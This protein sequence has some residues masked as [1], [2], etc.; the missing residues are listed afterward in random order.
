VRVANFPV[1]FF[2]CHSLDR[3]LRVHTRSVAQALPCVDEDFDNNCSRA[4]LQTMLE[5]ETMKATKTEIQL[6]VS[7]LVQ[8]RLE[9]ARFWDVRQYVTEKERQPGSIR[10]RGENAKALSDATLW[11]YIR[12]ADELIEE[13]TR[14]SRKKRIRLH[15]AKRQN[16]FAKAI[17]Q[18]DVRTALAA[19]DSE[20]KLLGLFP[21]NGVGVGIL[22]VA[23]AS[24]AA[25]N[26][27]SPKNVKDILAG[28]RT[29]H[30]LALM[31]MLGQD[32]P[33]ELAPPEISKPAIADDGAA[34]SAL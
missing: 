27:G 15:V 34:R 24:S 12:W 29:E 7:D 2:S 17:S 30:V 19:A 10:Y 18:G 31:E 11:R 23:Q 22:N 8:F 33:T 5:D 1:I 3:Q 16:L 28:L 14:S 20:A 21:A 25:T 26:D 32:N 13:D 6:R 9:G 4:I